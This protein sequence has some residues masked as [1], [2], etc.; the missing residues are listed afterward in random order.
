MEEIVVHRK[1]VAVACL[2]AALGGLCASPLQAQNYPTQPIKLIVPISVGSVTD[3]AARLMAQELEQRLG[4]SVVVINKPGGAMVIGGSECAKSP[5]DGYTVCLVN[6]DTMSFNPL[7]VPNLPY[8]PQKN[9]LPVINMYYVVEGFGIRPD[10]PLNSVSDLRAKAVAEPDKLNFGVLGQRT[11]SDAF[12]QWLGEQWQT[13]FVAIPYKGGSEIVN[14]LLSGA[15]DLTKIGLGNM[16]GQVKEGK[17][18]VLAITSMDRWS[19]LPDV[20]TIG[21][22]GLGGF[23]GSPIYWGV[24]VP[25]GTPA[26]IVRRLHDE[27]LGVLRGPKFAAFAKENF[28]D[29]AAGST[30]EFGAFLVKDLHNA[31]TVVERYMR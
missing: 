12:R 13:S 8:D 22:S 23:P 2:I 27:L 9:F 10:L 3:V 4:Q 19:Q 21:E 11:I 5:P 20:P 25:T 1:M 15:I 26:T 6:N 29:L 16:V 28:L 30:E 31:S 17:I 18:R 24:M 14:A 7:T